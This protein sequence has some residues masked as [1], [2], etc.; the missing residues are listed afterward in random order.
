[1]TTSSRD[2]IS[3]DLQGLKTAL[4]DR[5]NEG[6][7]LPSELVRRTLREMLDR[8]ALPATSSRTHSRRIDRAGGARLSLRMTRNQV[9]SVFEAAARAGVGAG[10][11]V[12]DLVGGVPVLARGCSRDALVTALTASCAEMSL[13]NRRMHE[14]ALLLRDSEAELADGHAELFEALARDIRAHLHLASSALVDLRPHGAT[15]EHAAGP[16]ASR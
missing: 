15:R 5:A 13:V 3:V 6:D 2:R 16:T 12:A 4:Y 14:L 7:L 11:Y 8:P 10:R 1:M 9:D